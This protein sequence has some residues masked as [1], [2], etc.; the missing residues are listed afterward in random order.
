MDLDIDASDTVELTL[1]LTFA[2]ADNFASGTDLSVTINGST[3][4]DD[5][6]DANGNDEGDMTLG[7]SA[8]SETHRL[9]TEGILVTFDESSFL[10]TS[11]DTAGINET[12]Q[13]TLEFDVTA[14]GDDMYID[15]DCSVNSAP[16]STYVTTA[17]VSLDNDTDG[18]STTCTDF[19]STGNEGSSSFE[20]LEGQT[21]HFTVT[22]LGNG[23]EAGGAGNSYTFTARLES[24]GYN[25][26]SDGAGDTQYAFDLADFHSS[27]VTVFDR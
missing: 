5:A 9:A 8:T 6:E 25:V 18:S 2:D 21:E 4:I 10:K 14:F 3:D 13:F 27:A 16:A 15:K 7:G 22:I 1:K 11:S 26:G 12:V 17:A 19:D 23:G 24:L 20:V